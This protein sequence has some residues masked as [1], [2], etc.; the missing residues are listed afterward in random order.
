MSTNDRSKTDQILDLLLDVLSERQERRGRA[1]EANDRRA[2]P[3][4]P[5]PSSEA[6]VPRRA[7]ENRTSRT[8]P[9]PPPVTRA[10]DAPVVEWPTPDEP[11]TGLSTH[12]A[13]WP[14]ILAADGDN[15]WP[16]PVKAPGRAAAD[17]VES[18]PAI[19][20]ER[21]LRRLA[22]L[23]VLLLIVVNIPFN[24][25]GL[26]LAR[27]MPDARSLIIR[28]GL[29]LKGSGEKIYVLENNQKRWITSLEAFEWHGYRWEQVNVVDDTFL[30]RFADGRPLYVLLKCGL[31]A[32]IYALED[33]QKRWIKDIETF[34]TE[35]FVWEDVKFIGCNT[36][37][38]IPT[39][40]PIPVNA[41]PSP[42]P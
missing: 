1:A 7:E 6:P 8:P 39:G 12:P 11:P 4:L 36:L 24:R 29:V 27:A 25:S 22:I 5:L 30:D 38:Q 28:D 40:L 10:Q 19:Q 13:D 23:L 42:E 21:M 31:S 16:E 14:A 18:L 41:G 33:G 9:Q 17:S 32:H 20:F 37:R 26:S 2:A 35:G 15:D 34:K 3:V